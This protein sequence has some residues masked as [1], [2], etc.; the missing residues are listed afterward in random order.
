MKRE[1]KTKV[2]M[3]PEAPLYP[4]RINKYLA[5]KHY[6]TRRGADE[7][8]TA[9]QVK[10]NG[11]VAVLGDKVTEEDVV[12]VKVQKNQPERLYFAYHKPKGIITH[13]PE[14][15]EEDVRQNVGSELV[16]KGVFPVGRLDKNSHGLLILTNDGRITDKLLNPKFD[17]EKE[18][19]VET[20]E[21]LRD[22][23]E[24]H[25]SLG[26]QIE[27]YKTKPCIVKRIDDTHFRIILREGKKH[28]IRRMVVA[29]HNEVRDL[30]RIR[31][32]NIP[33]GNI[34]K[35]KYRQIK[36]KEL[37]QFLTDLGIPLSPIPPP[38]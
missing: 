7:L 15:D 36:G 31:I 28:Q 9:R 14:G 32:M 16:S 17:H 21:R 10:I 4:M 37:T 22:S 3:A 2:K 6:A 5:F 38:K 1:S 24:K 18:Y 29:L 27:G 8:I 19:E 23:F 30:K 35:G 12:E 33:L 34:P 25:M 20:R 11:T 26:V 13:S